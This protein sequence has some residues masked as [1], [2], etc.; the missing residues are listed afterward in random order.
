LILIATPEQCARAIVDRAIEL[1]ATSAGITSVDDLKRAPSYVLAARSPELPAVVWPDGARSVV[2]VALAHPRDRP[3]LDWWSGRT[4]P[5]GNRVLADIVRGLCDWIPGTFGIG[6]TH[7]PY[8][9][10]RGG[11]YLK[12]AAVLAGLGTIGRNNLLMVPRHGPLVRLRALT[13]DI[14]LPSTGPAACDP[15]AG[16]PAPCHAA[17]PRSA[18]RGEKRTEDPQTRSDDL[19]GGFARAACYLQMDSD[20]AAAGEPAVIKYCRACELSCTAGPRS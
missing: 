9:V 18:F 20:I 6:C 11:I 5:P 14:D 16:C 10:Q 2:V 4:D 1:G 8:H 13:L 12:D 17:C 15:C 3:E 19:P 7:L